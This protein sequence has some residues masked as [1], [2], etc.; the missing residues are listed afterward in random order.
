MQNTFSNTQT[1]HIDKPKYM[2]SVKY[3]TNKSSIYIYVYTMF[4]T[5]F[6][7]V[8]QMHCSNIV[9][10]GNVFLENYIPGHEWIFPSPWG[11]SGLDSQ[12]RYSW[13]LWGEA[14]RQ[15][16]WKASENGDPSFSWD[17]ILSC[18]S[19]PEPLLDL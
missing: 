4:L 13:C 19:H 6:L 10:I 5:C 18:G 8:F 3:L 7:H 17:V 12:P 14:A 15:L 16:H 9:I 1:Y 11:F 2:D